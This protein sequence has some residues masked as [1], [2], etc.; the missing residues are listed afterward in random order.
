MLI[1]Q[2]GKEASMGYTEEALALPFGHDAKAV[3]DIDGLVVSCGRP[4][5]YPFAEHMG[6]VAPRGSLEISPRGK[7]GRRCQGRTGVE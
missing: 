4:E 1:L 5:I 7:F 2:Q 6:T 3:E